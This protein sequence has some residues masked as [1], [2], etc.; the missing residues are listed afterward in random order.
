MYADDFIFS[1]DSFNDAQLIANEAIALFL[2]RG[3][4]PVK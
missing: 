2:S 1:A 3:F 4:E